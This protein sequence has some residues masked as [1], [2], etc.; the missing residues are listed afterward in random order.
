VLWALVIFIFSSQQ[1]LPSLE[2]SAFD[3][4]LKKSAHIFV[5]AVLYFLL[6]R[7]VDKSLPAQAGRFKNA[8]S[9]FYLPILICLFYAI[10][11]EIHQSFVPGRYATLKD[12][13]FDMLG[14][15]IAFLRKYKYI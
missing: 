3:F 12:V 2:F 4:L 1:I 5:Y 14:V 6:Y 9:L 11:D 15:L 13:G 7:S 8:S 10:S